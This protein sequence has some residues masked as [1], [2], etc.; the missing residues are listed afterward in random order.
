MSIKSLLVFCLVVGAVV[1]VVM[2]DETPQPKPASI[3]ATQQ[4]QM[5]KA[6]NVGN[7]LQQSLDQRMQGSS[8]K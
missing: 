4:Q 8:V 1:W 2:K 7:D 3:T 6:A 5:Q